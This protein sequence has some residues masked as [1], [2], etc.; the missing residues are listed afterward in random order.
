MRVAIFYD[1]LNQWGGAERVLLDIIS[2]FPE[3]PLFTLV[4]DPQKTSWLPSTVK[5]IPSALNHLPFARHN[6]PILTPFYDL[7]LESFDFSSY[8]IVISTTSTIG[9]CLLTP[10]TTLFICYF[11]NV[12]RHLYHSSGLI[13]P[14]LSLYRKIDFIYSSRPDY[15]LCN[16]QTVSARISQTYHRPSAV[17][18]PGTDTD[19]FS[20]GNNSSRY[21]LIISRLVPHKNIDIAIRA[22]SRL[23]YRLLIIGQGRSR[24]YLQ[25]L[26]SPYRNI[27]FIDKVSQSRLI[28]YYRHCYALICPQV[29]D[30]GLSVI[31]AQACGKPVI[32]L[33]RGGI[34]ETVINGKT[35]IFFPHATP[36]SLNHAINRFFCC[37]FSPDICRQNSLHFSRSNFMLN[38]KKQVSSLWQTHQTTIS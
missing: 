24:R 28:N 10:P 17:I 6:P 35:G 26:A 14:L 23:P 29:E 30:F 11:H 33:N 36:S 2:L 12:N 3:A 16:S 18:Y 19:I 20:P 5:V 32:A 4:H 31:E 8:D 15:L 7:A 38:L 1:W 37:H 25:R 34:T 13:S 21:F 22:F 27:S 9:H